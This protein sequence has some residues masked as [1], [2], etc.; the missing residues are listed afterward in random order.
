MLNL[1]FFWL[2]GEG[3]R[4]AAWIR[5]EEQEE[6]KLTTEIMLLIVLIAIN[7]FF[8]ASEIALISL[9]DNK[10]RIQAEAGD[11]KSQKL[12]G[13]LKEPSRFLATIQIGI[14]LAG[15]LASAF[16]AESFAGPLAAYL[17]QYQPAVSGEALKTIIVVLITLILSYFTLVLGELVPKRVAMKKS[18][19]IAY[20]V[21]GPLVLLSKITSPFVKL[22][23]LSTNFIV[24]LFGIDPHSVDDDVT[25][26]E[27]RMMVDVGEEKGAIDQ[28]EK[29]MINNVFEFNNKTAED[30]MTHRMEL[31]ALPVTAS[32]KDL[33]ELN[34]A[35]HYSRIPI[36]IDTI[37]QISGILHVKDLLPLISGEGNE[38]FA[39]ES[40]LRKPTFI[41]VHKKIN[42]IFSDLQKA[43]THMAIV[44]DEYGGTAGIVTMED[45]V[46]E[47]LG[48]IADEYDDD[49]DDEILR[50]DDKTF[51]VKG[52]I[53]LYELERIL[54][55]ELPTE[56]FETLNGFFIHLLG[57]DIPPMDQVS[58]A[59]YK[60]IQLTT[61]MVSEKRIEKILLHL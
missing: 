14:T 21:V 60:D 59:T 37:D 13:L 33:M 44:V 49:E 58:R 10:V 6:F 2:A 5:P 34:Q 23:T 41:P 32:L 26:E 54:D 53:S 48:N 15:F 27:I 3:A 30:I 36:Y 1:V 20:T 38:S 24:R 57:G 50:I 9:N 51:E 31:A 47:I 28:H 52:T 22:L 4:R 40:F 12:M 17:E 29:A 43:R 42:E 45:L 16:A 11:R 55:V 46:E 56:E 7:A 35:E 25:E 18:E 8:A 19:A 61:L 39:L